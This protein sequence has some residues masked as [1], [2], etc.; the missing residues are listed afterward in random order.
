[1]QCVSFRRVTRPF[2]LRQI[3]KQT[4]YQ[5]YQELGIVLQWRGVR[6]VGGRLPRERM[7]LSLDRWL[8]WRRWGETPLT[9]W[10]IRS[11]IIQ[12]TGNITLG[13]DSTTTTTISTVAT[14]ESTFNITTTN[15]TGAQM[16]TQC[17]ERN[18]WKRN[19]RTFPTTLWNLKTNQTKFTL[20][21]KHQTQQWRFFFF[22]RFLPSTDKWDVTDKRQLLQQMR[23]K[24][25]LVIKSSIK[26]I[27][28]T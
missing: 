3:T 2:H 21:T 20:F 28:S 18:K 17:T 9:E 16:E 6:G 25:S 10:M 8:T 12:F 4:Q 24:T 27:Q 19:F 5:N 23:E 26:S 7:T 13:N 22:S 14:K 11:S 15:S 1:M